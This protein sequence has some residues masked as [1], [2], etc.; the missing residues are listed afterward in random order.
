MFLTKRNVSIEDARR[1]EFR[2]IYKAGNPGP[3]DAGICFT[4][5]GQRG[6]LVKFKEVFH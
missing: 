3:E 6:I 5:L 1:R 2:S 4:F